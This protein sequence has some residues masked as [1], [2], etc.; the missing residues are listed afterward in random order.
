L[1]GWFY[2]KMGSLFKTCLSSPTPES[3]AAAVKAAKPSASKAITTESSSTKAITAATLKILKT[4]SVLAT[5][6]PVL[7][8]AV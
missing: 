5:A 6:E 7:S 8:F 4:L 1:L 2:K 3:A